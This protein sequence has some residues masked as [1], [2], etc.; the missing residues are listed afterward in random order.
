MACSREKGTFWSKMRVPG[1][2]RPGVGGE[3]E[4]KAEEAG[5]RPGAGAGV[6]SSEGLPANCPGLLQPPL[7]TCSARSAD[8]RFS[9]QSEPRQRPH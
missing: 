8:A 6:G 4:V 2:G 7:L 5:Q 1:W 3:A 9:A